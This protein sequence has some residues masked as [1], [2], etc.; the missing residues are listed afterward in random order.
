MEEYTLVACRGCR[1]GCPVVMKTLRKDLVVNG[2]ADDGLLDATCIHGQR[3]LHVAIA[4]GE[5]C[6][7]R[8]G[9]LDRPRYK[10]DLVHLQLPRTIPRPLE[11][12]LYMPPQVGD[13]MSLGADCLFHAGL[14]KEKESTGILFAFERQSPAYRHEVVKTDRIIR[15]RSES[16][17]DDLWN[18][19]ITFLR[20]RPLT[21]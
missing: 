4:P 3:A 9:R 17:T 2:H 7:C 1:D 13:D 15:I 5:C 14:I 19:Y 6:A 18:D 10:L 12:V 16:C 20:L 21:R 8:P 11:P